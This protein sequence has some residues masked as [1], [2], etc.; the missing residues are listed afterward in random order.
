[1]KMVKAVMVCVCVL[2]A[3]FVSVQAAQT[4]SLSGKS[5]S[6]TMLCTDDAGSYCD[7]GMLNNEEFIFEGDAGDNSSSFVI[8]SLDDTLGEVGDIIDD[9]FDLFDSDNPLGGS[10]ADRGFAFEA[11]YAGVKENGDYYT[12]DINGFNLSDMLLLGSMKI[13]YYELETLP[14]VDIPTG[15]ELEDEATAYFMGIKQ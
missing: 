15:Y 5:Y 7:E 1:M 4:A 3:G 13:K 14:Y 12:F 10:Y 6:V 9:I 11:E 8:S 2:L